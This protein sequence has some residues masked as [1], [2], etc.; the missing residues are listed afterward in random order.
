MENK[1]ILN[2]QKMYKNLGFYKKVQQKI[3]FIKSSILPLH[4]LITIK[5]LLIL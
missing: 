5:L 4:T 2:R 3:C 1:I